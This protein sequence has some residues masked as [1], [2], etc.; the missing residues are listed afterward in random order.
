MSSDEQLLSVKDAIRHFGAAE[1]HAPSVQTVKRWIMSG[2]RGVKLHG[3]LLGGRWKLSV[4]AI[5]QFVREINGNVSISVPTVAATNTRVAN[6]LREARGGSDAS[7]ASRRAVSRV[8]KKAPR[9][10]GSVRGE[11]LSGDEADDRKG[12]NAIT[13]SG[14]VRTTGS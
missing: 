7:V 12:T 4:A 5:N 8:R 10:P 6:W 9:G 1:G 2:C 11:V 14:T 13:P 3:T